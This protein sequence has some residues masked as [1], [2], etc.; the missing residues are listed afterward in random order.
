MF[1][2]NLAFQVGDGD[3]VAVG[4]DQDLLESASS[5]DLV[6]D[7]SEPECAGG[8]QRSRPPVRPCSS[9]VDEAQVGEH[10]SVQAEATKV[11]THFFACA[12][13][14][15]HG[16]RWSVTVARTPRQ[17]TVTVDEVVLLPGDEAILAPEWVP[18]KEWIK[19]G[20]LSW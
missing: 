13:P 8:G 7:A 1:D 12:Q 15:Y 3:R 17:K 16:C 18:W 10:L 9:S 5:V 6:A 20:D 19:P 14:G 4:D 11:V 2:E